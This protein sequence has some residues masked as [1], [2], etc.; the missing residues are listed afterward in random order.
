[1]ALA[2]TVRRV[3]NAAR[4]PAAPAVELTIEEARQEHEI[5]TLPRAVAEIKEHQRL[6][7]VAREY[8]NA[9][10]RQETQVNNAIKAFALQED[11]QPEDEL[12]IGD[13]AYRY[14]VTRSEK[15][16]AEGLYQMLKDGKITDG[17]FLQSITVNKADAERVIG[18]HK[19]MKITTETAGKKLGLRK[20]KLD[21]PAKEPTLVKGGKGVVEPKLKTAAQEAPPRRTAT[22][23]SKVKP[24]RKLK[25]RR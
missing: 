14:D 20:T 21:V 8:T 13:A 2:T 4:P 9:V 19:L 11:M 15:I 6:S 10:N 25:L 1:M 16:S 18:Q 24:V 5:G 17:E 7:D 3:S 23:I 12:R 22:T